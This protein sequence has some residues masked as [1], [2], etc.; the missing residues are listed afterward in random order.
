MRLIWTLIVGLAFAVPVVADE[1]PSLRAG[2]SLHGEA[3]NEGPRQSA[4]LMGGTGKVHF[5]VT[6]HARLAQQLMDQGIGQLHG[7]W[8]FEAERTFRQVAALD[9]SCGMALWGMAMANVNNRSRGRGFLEKSAPYRPSMTEREQM[10]ID[11]WTAYFDKAVDDKKA[12][13]GKALVENLEK[14]VKRFPDDMEA[15][16]F[17][18]CQIWKN[19]SDGVEMNSRVAIDALLQ[20]VLDK[21]PDHPCHHYRI[22]LWDK[23]DPAQAI[24]SAAQCGQ[25]AP[26]VAHMWHMPGHTYSGLHRYADAAWQQEASARTDHAYMMRDRLLPDQIHNYAHNNEWLI[27]T[28]LKQGRAREGLELAMNMTELP[29]HPKW[30]LLTKKDCSASYGRKRTLEVLQTCE[31]W[32]ELISLSETTYLAPENSL[33]RQIENH[34]LIGR[35]AFLTNDVSRGER[36]LNQLRVW[37]EQVAL[38]VTSTAKLAPSDGQVATEPTNSNT[39]DQPAASPTESVAATTQ[40]EEKSPD[41]QDTKT[42]NDTQYTKEAN[43]TKDETD[44]DADEPDSNAADSNAPESKTAASN[45]KDDTPATTE[46][47][48]F[49]KQQRKKLEQAFRELSGWQVWQQGKATEAWQQLEGVEG[50][51]EYLRA[52]VMAAAGKVKEAEDVLQKAVDDGPGEV[53]PRSHL[54]DFC[55]QHD[56]Q[57]RARELLLEL[58]SLASQ[59]DQDLPALSRL[60]PIVQSLN[61]NSKDWRA[62][63]PIRQDVGIRPPL[64]SLGPMNWQPPLASE[65]TLPDVEGV[66]RNL[67]DYKGR[68]VVVI[69][70]LGFGCL[71]CVEQLSAFAPRADEFR[72]AGWELIAIGT[73][74]QESL[75]EALSSYGR[76]RIRFPLLTDPQ[77]S[78]FRAYRCFDDFEQK[79]L[80]GAFLIDAQGRTR[81]QDIAHEPFV[82]PEFLLGEARRVTA[83]TTQGRPSFQQFD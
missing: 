21:N 80:H 81:W 75:R 72:Q 7:F 68:N 20:Q 51:P 35:A 36:H 62:P 52:R 25:I 50:I 9:S 54:A 71:H 66:K 1:T 76:D 61:W 59:A 70:Y 22:H 15:K 56:K 26:H 28:W 49:N 24:L 44:D 63:E 17:L 29:R 53:L 33:G 27:R 4:Y 82:D 37:Q 46:A 2:H 55:W 77:L 34:R 39:P 31:L 3:F 43:A 19:S 42:A 8:F 23:N 5:P 57:D 16:A 48:R 11:A 14:L 41:T 83:L 60:A 6:T 64:D 47:P 79:P 12:E 32:D 65:W 40:G 58:R 67:A 13:S 18:A 38:E 73:D 10:Y 30:N 74:S 78:V 69:M 45:D